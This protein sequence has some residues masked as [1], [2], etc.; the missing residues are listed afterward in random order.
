MHYALYFTGFTIVL[1][2]EWAP[3][4][5]WTLNIVKIIYVEMNA[6]FSVGNCFYLFYYQHFL[7]KVKS[8][9]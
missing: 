1:S 9:W 2:T 6:L 7:R 5:Y 3:N 4:E 8:E